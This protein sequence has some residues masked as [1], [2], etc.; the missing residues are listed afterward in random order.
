M[1]SPYSGV[2]GPVVSQG[3]THCRVGSGVWCAE[4][5]RRKHGLGVGGFLLHMHFPS[6]HKQGGGEG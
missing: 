2:A 4:N 3:S 5:T 1:S 6:H